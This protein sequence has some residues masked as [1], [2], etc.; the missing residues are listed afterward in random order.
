MNCRFAGGMLRTGLQAKYI[1]SVGT[2]PFVAEARV[3]RNVIVFENLVWGGVMIVTVILTV[4]V[5][6]EN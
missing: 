1:Q 4:V 6:S 3:W 5:S 2:T